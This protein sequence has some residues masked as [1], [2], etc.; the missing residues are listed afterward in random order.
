MKLQLFQNEVPITG[1]ESYALGRDAFRIFIEQNESEHEKILGAYLIASD[2]P[3]LNQY[4]LNGGE[5]EAWIMSCASHS[6][7]RSHPFEIYGINYKDAVFFNTQE[8]I[9]ESSKIL[10][11]NAPATMR[12]LLQ[13]FPHIKVCHDVNLNWCEEEQY[14]GFHRY[15]SAYDGKSFRMYEAE[16]LFI[17]IVLVMQRFEIP[18][19]DSRF[20]IDAVKMHPFSIKFY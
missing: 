15:I 14:G 18:N 11:S 3:N 6:A 9:I 2:L 5:K 8:A 12:D 10:S 13:R 4:I 20:T 17:T 7:I 19:V 1:N 16:D